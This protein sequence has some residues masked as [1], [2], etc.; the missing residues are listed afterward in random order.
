[1]R[2]VLGCQAIVHCGAHGTLEWLPGKTV[3]L[4]ETCFPEIVTGAL[5][6]FYPFIV[7]N[8]GEAAQAKRRIAA[9]TIGHM[10]PPLVGAGL[11]PEQIELE[12]LV[13]EYVQADGLD[14]RRRDRLAR[15]ILDKAAETGLDRIAG[16]KPGS[17]QGSALKQI[18]AWLCDLKDFAIKDGQ[19][20]FAR[21]EPD[22]TDPHR[23]L[24]AGAEKDALLGALDGRFVPPGPSGSPLR[25]HCNVLPTG[26]NLFT[27]DP[28]AIP[29]PT[30][31]EMGKAAGDEVLRYY[32]QENGDWPRALVI[33]LWASASLRTGGEEI[34]QGLALM[35]CRPRWDNKTGRVMG[36]EVLPPASFGRPRVDV[37]WRISGLFRDMFPVQ[38]ALIGAAVEAVAKRAEDDGENPLAADA[39]AHGT[40][41]QRVFGSSPGT[42]GSGAESR[43][44][45]GDWRCREEIGEAYLAAASCTFS[46]PEAT[47]L[48]AP[49][50]FAERVA[51]AD[52]LVH[53]GDDSGRDILEGSADVAFM[54][55][56]SAA[57]A[58]LGRNADVVALDTTDPS[59]PRARSLVDA[60]SRVVHARAVNPRYIRG[61]MRHGPRG[62]SDFAE[63]V[64]RLVAFAETTCAIPGHLIDAI[65]DAYVGDPEIRAFMLRENPAA[66]GSIADRLLSARRRG[67]WHPLRNSVDNELNQL[68]EEVRQMGHPS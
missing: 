50:A 48:A 16:I 8:P 21:S 5:P 47:P 17:D 36:I 62:A 61:Q 3:A 27:I 55:G 14:G 33:D 7:S 39:R 38:I 60:V 10:P 66:A 63:T 65:H 43:I 25:G 19:H 56:F 1:M 31:L 23:L 42:Y 29:T 12:R 9:V 26:R 53:S 41:P 32:V 51:G 24:S 52:L 67:L 13:D 37:T 18:D 22:C 46:G 44:A 11:T 15:L 59:R 64:D 28:R 68:A 6:V 54:G 45:S 40:I 35:G 4:S 58:A 34:A 30:A 49:G 20:I 2:E 57:L